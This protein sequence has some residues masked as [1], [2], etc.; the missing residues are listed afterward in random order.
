MLIFL[1]EI[2][3]HMKDKHILLDEMKNANT[4]HVFNCCVFFSLSIRTASSEAFRQRAGAFQP[5][6]RWELMTV[7]Y[8]RI[9]I[10]T[11]W[12]HKLW[13]YLCIK[14]PW[15]F[16]SSISTLLH[17]LCFSP[18]LHAQRCQT[19]IKGSFHFL[20]P[21][22]RCSVFPICKNIWKISKDK[23]TQNIT[24]CHYFH[25]FT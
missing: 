1:V 11:L 14:C 2:S 19:H 17:S 18:P 20:C 10:R 4:Q 13:M 3:I 5:L 9:H 12:F 23:F 21:F 24:F 6:N 7:K 25:T 22:A 15:I 8:W 16:T